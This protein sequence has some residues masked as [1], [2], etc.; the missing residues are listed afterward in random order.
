M[1]TLTKHSTSAE[2]NVCVRVCVCQLI[3]IIYNDL[4]ST[5]TLAVVFCFMTGS[6]EKEVI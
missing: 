4:T 6:L 3:N 1:Q 2:G 5:I